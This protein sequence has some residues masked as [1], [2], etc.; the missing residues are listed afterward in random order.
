MQHERQHTAGELSAAASTV[1]GEGKQTAAAETRA[2]RHL[3]TMKAVQPVAFRWSTQFI[4]KS[5]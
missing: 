5:R 2:P 3:P 1:G 4:T